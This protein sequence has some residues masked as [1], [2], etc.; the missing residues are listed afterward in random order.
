MNVLHNLIIIFEA[1][2]V[3]IFTIE[4][5]G[6]FTHNEKPIKIQSY[7]KTIFSISLHNIVV[8]G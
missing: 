5:N 6:A 2:L 7:E 8:N 3:T 4:T 1:I